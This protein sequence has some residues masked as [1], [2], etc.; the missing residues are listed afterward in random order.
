MATGLAIVELLNV[1]A[2][3]QLYKA[4]PVAFSLDWPTMQSTSL[5]FEIV[6]TGLGLV[7]ILVN[8]E[9]VTLQVVLVIIT[10]YKVG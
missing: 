1:A 6:Y 9:S 5:D 4:P 2:G 3:L 10:L 7:V 8:T